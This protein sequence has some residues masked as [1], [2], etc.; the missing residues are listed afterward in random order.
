M[1]ETITAEIAAE[2]ENAAMVIDEAT[3]RLKVEAEV[4]RKE[5]E[6]RSITALRMVELELAKLQAEREEYG[7]DG[8]MTAPA[9]ANVEKAIGAVKA[10][11]EHVATSSSIAIDLATTRFKDE[12]ERTRISAEKRST[13]VLQHVEAQTQQLRSMRQAHSDPVVDL[14]AAEAL[15]EKRRGQ[16][17]M[18]RILICCSRI[19]ICCS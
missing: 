8:G 12:A 5:N 4:A 7:E 17:S 13:Q 3:A 18:E 19:M 15:L 16:F 14:D 2:A 6:E 9:I 11:T 1:I 10:E